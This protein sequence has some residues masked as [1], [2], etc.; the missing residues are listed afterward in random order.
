MSILRNGSWK[1]TVSGAATV[2]AFA[3]AYTIYHNFTTEHAR[4]H[5]EMTTTAAEEATFKATVTKHI[6]ETEPL[7]DDYIKTR[8]QTMLNTQAI[9]VIQTGMASMQEDVRA[10]RDYI[11]GARP[12]EPRRP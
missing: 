9:T 8:Q 5:G 4:S 10:I 2:A 1:G 6:E 7:K 3:L 11:Y 12:R